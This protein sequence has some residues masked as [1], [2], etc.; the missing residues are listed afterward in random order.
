MSRQFWEWGHQLGDGWGRSR[1]S[2]DGA[3]AYRDTDDGSVLLHVYIVAESG[4]SA[5]TNKFDSRSGDIVDQGA[6]RHE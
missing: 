1:C 6:D 5:E 3:R 2:L 4:E